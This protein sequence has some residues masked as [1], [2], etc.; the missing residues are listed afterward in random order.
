[1]ARRDVSVNQICFYMFSE[2]LSS[3]RP[4]DQKFSIICHCWLTHDFRMN[5]YEENL[6]VKVTIVCS[7]CFVPSVFIPC[8]RYSLLITFIDSPL[9]VTSSIQG[10]D[11]IFQPTMTSSFKIYF[12]QKISKI[13]LPFE[14]FFSIYQIM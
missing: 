2:N 14:Q 1:M 8:Y 3:F 6:V 5:K 7:H 9:A 13:I 4:L 11:V 10:C 12:K